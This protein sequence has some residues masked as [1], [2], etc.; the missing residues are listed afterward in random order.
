M[1][2]TNYNSKGK[3]IIKSYNFCNECERKYPL[4]VRYCPKCNS[5]LFPLPYFSH[6]GCSVN[7]E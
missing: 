2:N 6:E 3:K 7:K 5:L 4:D 1:N